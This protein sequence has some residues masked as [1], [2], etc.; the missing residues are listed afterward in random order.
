MAMGDDDETIDRQR[1]ASRTQ[2]SFYASTPAYRGVLEAIG[3]G[4]LQSK[5]HVMSKDGLWE[6]MGHEISDNV[7]DQLIV[8]GRPEEIPRLVGERFGTRLDRVS[9]Y[10]GWPIEDSE[11]MQEI[12]Q[13]FH[14]LE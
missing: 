6:Q 7:L 5:L 8:S 14:D 3:E 4:D 10:F 11:R 9:S 12:V 13:A 2:L 1:K